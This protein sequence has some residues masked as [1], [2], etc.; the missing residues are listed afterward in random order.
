MVVCE[1]TVIVADIKQLVQRATIT[2]LLAKISIRRHFWLHMAA[3]DG[4][5]MHLVA[6]LCGLR[7]SC[8]LAI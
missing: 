4:L 6:T 7:V 2:F 5:G 1:G 3:L 8:L